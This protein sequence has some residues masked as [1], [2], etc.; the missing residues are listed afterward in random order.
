MEK[1]SNRKPSTRNRVNSEVADCTT[2]SSS[3]RSSQFNRAS[4]SMGSKAHSNM[5]LCKRYIWKKD[6]S[7]LKLRSIH[8]TLF[9]CRIQVSS[10]KVSTTWSN[11]MIEAS[12]VSIN[13]KQN[14]NLEAFTTLGS[15]SKLSK[16]NKC[17]NQN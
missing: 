17:K 2:V 16:T 4:F 11:E 6:W 14:R 13:L 1:N 3:K 5:L 12:L 10:P 8:K 9:K 15:K 7:K